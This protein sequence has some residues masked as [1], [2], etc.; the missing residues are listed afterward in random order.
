MYFQA[1]RVFLIYVVEIGTAAVTSAGNLP[2]KY[3]IHIVS[4]IWNG[5]ENGEEEKLAIAVINAY[6]EYRNYFIHKF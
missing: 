1:L 5:G 4:P 2:A 3:I 6:P